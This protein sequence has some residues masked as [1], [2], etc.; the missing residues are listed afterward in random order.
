MLLTISIDTMHFQMAVA[1]G[2]GVPQFVNIIAIT[3]TSS[4]TEIEGSQF[5]IS[6]TKQGVAHYEHV[7][8]LVVTTCYQTA[9]E[10][11]LS[12]IFRLYG[13]HR[14][15]T[16]LHPYKLPVEV[17][18]IAQKLARLEGKVLNTTLSLDY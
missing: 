11:L 14:C 16:N 15:C 8:Q 18:V 5:L 1:I 2:I 10:S 6:I 7:V 9:T 17:E 12:L 4:L 3:F 13:R